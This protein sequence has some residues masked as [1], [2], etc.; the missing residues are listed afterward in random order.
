MT[1]TLTSAVR[2]AALATLQLH[3]PGSP[4]LDILVRGAAARRSGQLR[5]W[6]V[7][8]APTGWHDGLLLVACA[9][10]PTDNA[11]AIVQNAADLINELLCVDRRRLQAELLA[12]HAIELASVDPLTQLGN[13]RSWL[14]ALQEEERR[15]V[16]YQAQSSIA[17]IDLDG[18]KRINDNEGHAAGDAQLLNAARAIKGGARSVDVVCRL[19]GDEF[20]VLA[21]ETGPEGASRLA[22][23]LLQA[24]GQAGVQASVGVATSADGS[25]ERAWHEADAEMYRHKR[26]RALV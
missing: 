6:P 21:P 12:R 1:K 17:V 16:R 22:S 13:R 20:A 11:P 7:K 15:A 10:D 8:I 2:A 18:L 4:E 24:L 19:G 9:A 3:V 26:Q 23:R 14:K 25:L 5:L